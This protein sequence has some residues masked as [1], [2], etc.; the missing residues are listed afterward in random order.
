MTTALFLAVEHPVQLKESAYG[1]YQLRGNGEKTG[2]TNSLNQERST[3][4]LKVKS[5]V[6]KYTSARNIFVWKI[7]NQSIFAFLLSYVDCKTS[8]LTATDQWTTTTIRL[9]PNT[10]LPFLLCFS[11]VWKDD[12]KRPK[13]GALP[14]MN[15]PQKSH[16]TKK[17]CP[18]AAR[19]VVKDLPLEPAHKWCYNSF[20]ELSKRADGLKL[21]TEWN[22]QELTEQYWW[23]A[24]TFSCYQR[25]N[26]QSMIALA[27]LFQS[28]DGTC[29]RTMICITTI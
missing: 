2:W 26:W 9:V 21:I 7:Y 8:N 15:M 16:H 10:L 18:S 24:I 23:K 4:T 27:T 19:S 3:K 13:F 12:E 5:A 1:N 28:L 29:Q 22:L 6:T 25:L 20:S 14:T 17:P 11:R